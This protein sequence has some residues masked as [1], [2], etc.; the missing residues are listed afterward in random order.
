[1]TPP[2]AGGNPLPVRFVRFEVRRWD[3]PSSAVEAS[4]A[5]V[6]VAAFALPAYPITRPTYPLPGLAGRVPT[7]TH[8]PTLPRGN[9]G[10]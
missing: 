10:R 1:M 9:V 6:T 8:C 3:T 5:E 2:Y 7:L 4:A